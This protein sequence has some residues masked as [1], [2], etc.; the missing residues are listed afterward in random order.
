MKTTVVCGVLG[1][2]KTTFLNNI[3]KHDRGK[4]VVLVNDFGNAGIDG[5]IISAGGIDTIELP[6][7]CVCCTL[8]FDLITTITKIREQLHPENLFI[9][10]SGVASPSGVIDVLDS[11]D[12]QPVTIVGIVDATEFLEAYETDMY[13]WFFKSQVTQ[14]DLVLVNKTDLVD[15]MKTEKIIGVIEVLNPN[16]VIVPAVNAMLD[17]SLLIHN[18]KITRKAND[19]GHAFHAETVTMLFSGIQS[20]DSLKTLFEK[21]SSGEFGNV[22]RAKALV[23]TD[24]GPYRFDLASKLVNTEIFGKEITNSRLVIIGTDLKEDKIRKGLGK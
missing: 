13:G 8:R 1:A 6:S 23:Q 7:G 17:E 16:A 22:M 18:T 2:G 4:T 3:L 21:M 5:E 10:P 14:S 19:P 20:F 24:K 11:L 15:G 12:I 9:E